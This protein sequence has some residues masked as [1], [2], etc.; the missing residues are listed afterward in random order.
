MRRSAR[1]AILAVTT[2]SLALAAAALL[3]PASAA[4]ADLL[5]LDSANNFVVCP[6]T[7]S[8]TLSVAGG[9][10]VTSTPPASTVAVPHQ[11]GT[12]RA[13]G[14]SPG[15]WLIA[16]ALALLVLLTAP[17]A[18]GRRRRAAVGPL[19]GRDAGRISPGRTGDPGRSGVFRRSARPTTVKESAIQHPPQDQARPTPSPAAPEKF[20]QPEPLPPPPAPPLAIVAGPRP[21][22]PILHRLDVDSLVEVVAG[23]ETRGA[24]DQDLVL[25]LP[26][27]HG[28]VI[29][30]PN[31]LIEAADLLGGICVA[32]S[33][34]PL[35]SPAVAQQA[36]RT[37][38]DAVG[39]PAMRCHPYPLALL[40]RAG[41]LRS[42]LADL[43]EGDDNTDWLTTALL[44]GR[45]N[46]T[47][48][49]AS[50]VFHILD[51][52]GTDA[53][54]VAGRAYVGGEPT[55]VLVDPTPGAQALARAESDLADAGNRPLS[56]LLDYDEATASGDDVIMADDVL[57]TPLW[58]SEFCTSL[59]QAAEVAHMT[60]CDGVW[61]QDLDL[62]LLAALQADLDNR[63]RPILSKHWPDST[64]TSLMG[65]LF[66]R[67]QAGDAVEAPVTVEG[68]QL[69][70]SVRLNDGY[71]GGALVLPRQGWED[72]AV[73]AGALTVWP[74]LFTHP[75]EIKPLTE[76][77]KYQLTVMW[78]I[79]A[80][81]GLHR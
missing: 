11:V 37:V 67:R 2:A 56:D 71:E 69:V 13:G 72:R 53:V 76:G 19:E 57:V 81:A 31:E 14:T 66:Q 29:A 23:L 49:V 77:V 17:V 41:S 1:T 9:A 38:A 65:A 28:A 73:P 74:S 47:L 68:V 78:G 33:P 43:P 16:V 50:L 3:L 10:S 60:A 30:P 58:T 59:I 48:D 15:Q 5:C 70:G 12:D 32:S 8:T 26:A 18:L 51:G 63:I 25:V 75:C 36:E 7:T 61:L 46:L 55:L 4:R 44:S 6:T 34:R 52:T 20:E 27:N 79:P 35:A 40:G 45:D 21:T 64:G 42:L 62:D 22:G 24:D 39:H 80:T 54:V